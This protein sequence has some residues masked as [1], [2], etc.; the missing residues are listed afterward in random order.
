M[1]DSKI[2][3]LTALTGANVVPAVDV[4][5]IVDVSADETKKITVSELLIGM[6]V[7]ASAAELNI[8]DGVTR[9]AT[10]LNYVDATSSIQTQLDAKL[11]SATAASTYEPLKGAN[12]NYVTD[13][14]LVVIG[15]TSGTNTGDQTSIVGISGTKAQFD[16]ACSDGNFAYQSDL[17][18]Y[19][20]NSVPDVIQLACSDETTAISAGTAKVTFRMPYAMTVTAVRASLTT[21]QTS[22]NIFTV[23]INDSGTSI[24]ST[25]LTID[26]TEKTSTTAVTAAVISDTALADDAEIT[27]DVDQIGD[28]TAKGLKITII[29]TR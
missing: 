13:S 16:T 8:L 18:S 20:L 28:G 26:N 4:L 29:G 7:T 17:S 5:P 25:K 11:A 27:I 19:R 3:A 14:Q 10:Q 1:A 24:L 12:D 15:N 22:G 6:G 23:D 21:A 2:T 9:T